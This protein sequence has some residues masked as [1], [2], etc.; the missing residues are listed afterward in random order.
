VLNFII[1]VGEG[2]VGDVEA[3]KIWQKKRDEHKKK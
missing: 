2:D 3:K 1:I